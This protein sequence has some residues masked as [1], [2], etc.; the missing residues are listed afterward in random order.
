MC[1]ADGAAVRHDETISCKGWTFLLGPLKIQL[2][3]IDIFYWDVMYVCV[4]RIHDCSPGVAVGV[5]A[6]H[7]VDG[8]HTV[9]R[10]ARL[11][12]PVSSCCHLFK[13]VAEWMDQR[14]ATDERNAG[15]HVAVCWPPESVPWHLFRSRRHSRYDDHN[16]YRCMRH[17]DYSVDGRQLFHAE[18]LNIILSSSLK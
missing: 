13:R 15:Q 7:Q 11:L 4:S 2:Y 17:V 14:S 8:C 6:V 18:Y 10:H 16:L 1:S 5:L 9:L 3:D 12:S